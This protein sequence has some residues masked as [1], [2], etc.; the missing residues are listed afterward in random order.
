MCLII[1]AE[2]SENYN[3]QFWDRLQD[4]W[5]KLSELDSD[6]AHP[7]LNDFSDYYD[8]YREYQF[9]DNNPLIDIENAFEKG[10]I[11]MEN[12]DIPSAVLCFES[13]VKQDPDN[14]EIWQLLGISQA[15]NEKVT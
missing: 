8:T 12:G 10:K 14:A 11:F 4:E 15:E 2:F 6:D 7:W 1:S 9:D 13:A 5:K 3:K